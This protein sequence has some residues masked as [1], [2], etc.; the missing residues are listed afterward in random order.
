MKHQNLEL[1]QGELDD[2][3]RI[4]RTVSGADAVICTLGPPVKRTY[5]GWAVLEGHKNIIRAMETEKARRFIT[6]ATPSVKSNK[7]VPSINTR[8]PTIMAK[9]FLP[10]AYHEIVQVGDVVTNSKLDWTIVRFISPN[11]NSLFGKVKVTFGETKIKWGITRADIAAYL[12]SQI[13]DKQQI[14]SMP[15]IGR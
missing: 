7:Y 10:K 5:E 3:E 9:L 13:T 11:N 8:M 14:R 2:Y 12:I 4:K 1:I 6:I 15:I